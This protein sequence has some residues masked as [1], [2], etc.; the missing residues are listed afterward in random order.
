MSQRMTGWVIFL[1]ALGA[2]LGML[3]NEVAKW[4]DWSPL[5]TPATVGTFMIHI[6][7]VIAAFVGGKYLPQFGA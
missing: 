1:A 6:G 5:T 4:P 7:T 2:M 3:G